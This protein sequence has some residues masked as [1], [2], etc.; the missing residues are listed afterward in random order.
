[1][2]EMTKGQTEAQISEALIKFEKE[3]MG[4]GPT[5]AKTYIIRDML[6]VRL[7]EILTP[8]EE[9][10][11][12]TADGAVERFVALEITPMKGYTTATQ[13]TPSKLSSFFNFVTLS[14]IYSVLT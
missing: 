14:I 10:L 9:Q 2:P 5:E 1:M 11:A 3:Y 12:K 4:R 7:K 8:A 6:L 13:K